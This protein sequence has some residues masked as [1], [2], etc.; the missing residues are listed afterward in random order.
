MRK[1][2]GLVVRMMELLTTATPFRQM[3]DMFRR[4]NSLA[5]QPPGVGVAVGEGEGAKEGA[6]EGEGEGE[7][8]RVEGEDEIR[9]A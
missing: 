4:A 8:E 2:G 3:K 5:S 1:E 7:R 6:E 9:S